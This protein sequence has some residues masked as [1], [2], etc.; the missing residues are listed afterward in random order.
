MIRLDILME[1][2]FNYFTE[3]EKLN[4]KISNDI[5]DFNQENCSQVYYLSIGLSIIL[6]IAFKKIFF[7]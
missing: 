7:F 6:R 2:V 1:K 3:Q 5:N 4:Q